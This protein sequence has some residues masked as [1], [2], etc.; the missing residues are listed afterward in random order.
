[1]LKASNFRF[2]MS[3]R[4]SAIGC[5]GIGVPQLLGQRPQHESDHVLNIADN[6]RAGGVQLEDIELRWQDENSLTG[7]KA[8]RIPDPT[9]AG[10]F[11]RRFG[12]ADILQPQECFNRARA[13]HQPMDHR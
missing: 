13:A 7:L 2:E 5:G 10:N 12:A 4:V 3:N 6:I 8:Q 11:T 9:T 1:M